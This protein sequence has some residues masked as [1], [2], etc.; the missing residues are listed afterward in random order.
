MSEEIYVPYDDEDF[1]PGYNA[2]EDIEV[3]DAHAKEV[4]E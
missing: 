3:T 1:D 4:K 2:E